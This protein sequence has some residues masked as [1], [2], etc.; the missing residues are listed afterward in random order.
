MT[1]RRSPRAIVVNESTA[2]RFFP[3]QNPLELSLSMLGND[4]TVVGV[5][6]DVPDLR[7]DVPLISPTCRTCSIP[8]GSP[9]SCARRFR[10]CDWSKASDARFNVWIKACRWPMS[11]LSTAH[12]PHPWAIGAWFSG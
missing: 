4:W 5:V 7:V 12:S 8:P 11:A 10:R 3:G 6:A 2:R 9:S 1:I